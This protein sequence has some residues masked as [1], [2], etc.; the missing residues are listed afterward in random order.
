MK[1]LPS[2]QSIHPSRTS[3]ARFSGAALPT[4]SDSVPAD[5]S[6]DARHDLDRYDQQLELR[7]VVGA[8]HLVGDQRLVPALD[9]AHEVRP[10]ALEGA[11]CLD[12]DVY[13]RGVRQ[14][15]LV[16]G[17]HHL[18]VL[19]VGVLDAGAQ[20]L[21]ARRIGIGD[22]IEL[23]AALGDADDLVGGLADRLPNDRAR[24]KRRRRR[25]A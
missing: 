19:P 22:E 8:G 25:R 3:T 2:A 18:G 1:V 7:Q 12:V 17:D 23:V 6:E 21:V 16:L 20:Q 24:A 11:L 4:R 15:D 14:V 13:Q 5:G 10:A 9:V